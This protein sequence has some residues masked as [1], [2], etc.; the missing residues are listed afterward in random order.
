MGRTKGAKD[1][2]TRKKRPGRSMTTVAS[3]FNSATGGSSVSALAPALSIAT[4]NTGSQVD[5]SAK[6][7]TWKIPESL[8][9]HLGWTKSKKCNH[10]ASRISF[11]VHGKDKEYWP[12]DI[13][14]ELDDDDQH[15]DECAAKGSAMG[16]FLHAVS[17]R[18][19]EEVRG[20]GANEKW[21][22]KMI[23]DG[24]WRLNPRM[25]KRICNKLGLEYGEPSYYR[26][27][28]VWLPDE[29]WGAVSMPPC[30]NCKSADK[31]SPHD[32]P[33]AARRVLGV[34]THYY[35]MSQRYIC[36][37]CEGESKKAKD[38]HEMAAASHNLRLVDDVV[39]PQMHLL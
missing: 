8:E 22:M 12:D 7:N 5:P 2:R 37:T 33:H 39:P 6:S 29:R 9:P 11:T 15:E 34:D 23:K 18:L 1:K 19:Q 27:I 32:F 3:P 21:L 31:V 25:A 38:Q 14:A 24:D 36:H 17:K 30:V 20:K 26:A 4:L 16:I 13:V 35:V 28:H 10:V